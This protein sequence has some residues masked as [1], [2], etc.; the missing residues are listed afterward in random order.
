MAEATAHDAGWTRSVKDVFAGATGGAAQ[1]LL[2]ECASMDIV[3][4]PDTR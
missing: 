1:V 2:G 3:R 4:R